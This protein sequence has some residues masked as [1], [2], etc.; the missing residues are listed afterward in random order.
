MSEPGVDKTIELYLRADS[1]IDQIKHDVSDLMKSD[2]GLGA[3]ID[4]VLTEQRL[5]KERFEE[6]V[7]RTVASTATKVNDLVALVTSFKNEHEKLVHTFNVTE[8]KVIKPLADN[9]KW[10][11]RGLL[12]VVF[13]S[14][15][16]AVMTFLWNFRLHP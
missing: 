5:L 14:V 11:I 2:L 3:K 12:G 9:Q 15:F 10:M 1:K 16:A 8:E 6:G 7:S 4:V 13:L